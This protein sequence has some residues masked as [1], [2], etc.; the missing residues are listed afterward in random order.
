MVVGGIPQE[1][2]QVS[3]PLTYPGYRCIIM[4]L[5]TNKWTVAEISTHTVS[6]RKRERVIGDRALLQRFAYTLVTHGRLDGGISVT[7]RRWYFREWSLITGGGG[8]TKR[9]GGGGHVK[10]YPC[11]KG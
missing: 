7:R 5:L 6:P 9:E 8:A 3:T 4:I 1:C 10:F 11:T 2:G